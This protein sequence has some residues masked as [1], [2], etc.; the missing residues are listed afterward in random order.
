MMELGL[1][2]RL[3]CVAQQAYQINASGFVPPSPPS[4]TPLPSSLVG[5]LAVPACQVAGDNNSAIDAAMVAETQTEVILAFRGTEPLGGLSLR[6]LL[7]WL[8]DVNAPLVT[9]PGQTGA[10]HSGFVH[11]L[12]M[13]WSWIEAQL[14]ALDPEKPLYVTGHSKG[15]AMANLAA[16]R[17][18]AAGRKTSVYTFEAARCG[19]QTFADS[20]AR[21]VPNAFRYEFQDDLV[22]HLPPDALVASMLGNVPLLGPFVGNISLGYV[23]VGELRFINWTGQVVPDST[24]LQTE[25]AH[26]LAARLSSFGIGDVIADHSIAPRSGVADA[27]CPSIWN[28]APAPPLT[29]A[30]QPPP[31]GIRFG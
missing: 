29:V 15:G 5:Y 21:L 18:A 20:F 23:P 1:P 24:A 16:A 31:A 30:A 14:A 3:L 19:G 26:R 13:L 6:T 10:V 27:V 9:A 8:N 28:A 25:R 7:D 4:P 17:L 22:P 12:D 11:A 2:G